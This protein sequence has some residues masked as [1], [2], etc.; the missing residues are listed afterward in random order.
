VQSRRITKLLVHFHSLLPSSS[1]S[2]REMT[3]T[4]PHQH[5]IGFQRRELLQVGFSVFAGLSLGATF[6]QA[7]AAEAK[8]AKPK[9]VI[10]IFQTGAPSHIDT[11]DPKPD[12]PVGIRG[13]FNSIA[14]SVPGVRYGEH[15]P[16]LAQR[17]HQTA[18]VRTFAHKDN[19]HTAATHHILTGSLQPGVRFDKPLSRDDWP[20]FAAGVS[21]CHPPSD[22]IPAGVTL[23]TFLASGPLVWPGQHGGFLGPKHDPW[24]I[25]KNPNAKDFAVEN[26]QLPQGLELDDLNNRVKLLD[27]VNAQQKL[28][29]TSAEAKKLTD[30]QSQAVNLLTRGAVARAFELNREPA[31]MRDKYGRH[32]FGQSML[33][34]RRLVEAGVPVVQANMGGVQNWDSHDNNFK[35][36]KN[37]LLPPLD[38]GVS[39]LLDDLTDSGLI[40][41]VMVVVMG[42]FGRT[43]KVDTN[44]GG[45]DHWAACFSGLFFG[46]GVRGGQVL[47]KSDATAAYPTT[48]PYNP[49]DLGATIYRQL[50]IDPAREL[51][52]RTARPVQLNRGTVMSGLFA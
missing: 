48:T 9:Q 31:K 23:P 38:R 29:A 51:V 42:E 24:Q 6:Q 41:D 4:A 14:T 50:G 11:F 43:P 45:R 21:F 34:A 40:D 19:N 8:R 44:N 7:N 16:L 3:M 17:A 5:A 2:I 47:G 15:L 32:Q 46:G 49:D 37:D 20:C 25:I 1:A 30:Q 36:L 28:L 12:A 26:L 35:R 52:D 18:V 27:S 22:G 33:L 10:L 39:A 13:E